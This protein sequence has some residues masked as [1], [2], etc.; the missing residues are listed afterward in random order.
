MSNVDMP[1]EPAAPEGARPDPILVDPLSSRPPRSVPR[2]SGG[3]SLALAVLLAMIAVGASGYVGWRQW[4]QEQGS[5]ADSQ[6]VA[7]LQQR[8]G[9]LETTLAGVNGERSSLNQRLSDA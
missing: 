1:N 6:G 7:S 9:A 2:A 8:V 4:Q 3:G 5:A